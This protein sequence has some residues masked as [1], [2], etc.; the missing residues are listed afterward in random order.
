MDDRTKG[1]SDRERMSGRGDEITGLPDRDE[2]DIPG[3]DQERLRG[4]SAGP[5][6]EE[7]P[8]HRTREIRAEIEQTRE[9]MSETIDAIQDKLR[10]R[11]IV[12][13]ATESVRT[14]TSDTVRQISDTVGSGAD[15]LMDGVFRNPIPVAMVSIG[16]AGLAWLAFGGKSR[17]DDW[18]RGSS[19]LRSASQRYDGGESSAAQLLGYETAS[20]YARGGGTFTARKAQ[21][22]MQRMLRENPLMIG[23]AAIVVGAAVGMTLP[24]TERENQLMG[25]ARDNVVDGVQEKVRDTA[26]RV[27]RAASDVVDKV[28]PNT[29]TTS[30]NKPGLSS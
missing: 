8:T 10:P 11:N 6:R 16:V 13:Q 4:Y 24:E 17:D 21:N 12:A 28:A 1:V 26:E 30:F 23:A 7:A 14:A 22:H 20:T 19:Q 15:D 18:P 5:P 3:R 27:Q 29:G 25:E 2:D 9:D